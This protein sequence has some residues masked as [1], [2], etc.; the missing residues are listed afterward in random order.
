MKILIADDHE[1][2]RDGLTTAFNEAIP[3]SICE[4]AANA[5]LTLEQIQNNGP[6]DLIVL[7]LVMPGSDG[8]RLLNK[9]CS[10][11]PETP[12]VVLSATA[13]PAIMRKAIDMGASGFIP[14]HAGKK[15]TLR[16]VE[17]VLSGGVYVPP[18]VMTTGS[19]ETA[20]NVRDALLLSGRKTND[21]PCLTRRQNDVLKFLVQGD[22]NKVIARN[23]GL[24]DN[25]VKI[26]ITAILK[27]LGATNRTQAVLIAQQADIVDQH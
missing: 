11:T 10:Q 16:A 6:F 14:K 4:Q 7:D 15:V 25:T 2:I 27:A 23:L 20:T 17:L 26:H 9:I 22:S 13:E 21:I 8:F 5:E 24:S 19:G 3:E 18:E 1:L 12:V